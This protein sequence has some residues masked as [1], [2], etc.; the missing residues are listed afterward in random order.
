MSKD[1][2]S[3]CAHCPIDKKERICLVEGGRG[4]KFCPTLNREDAIK[5]AKKE[6]QREEIREFARQASVQEGECYA[7]RDKKP[8]TKF[9]IK[10][11]VQEICEFAH[12]MG[13]KRLGIAFCVGMTQEASVL[14]KILVNQGFEVVSVMCKVGRF[15]KELIGV[16]DEEKI[17]IGEFESMCNSVA[18]AKVLNQEK[19]EL[20]ILVGLCVGHDSL[21]FKYSDAY[22]TVLVAKDRVLGHNPVA[23]LYTSGSYYSR[24][25]KSGF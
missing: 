10:P 5:E 16:K 11:R 3:S 12:K 4:P 25:M 14:N 18:Q 19:T 23:A 17:Q 24:M 6:Y 21:F 8:Y 1:L 9:P 7:G 22:T 15:P 13:F 2:T 20:N